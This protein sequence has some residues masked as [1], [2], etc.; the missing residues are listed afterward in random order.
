MRSQGLRPEDVLLD[1][2]CG[3]LRG[4]IHFIGY[5]LPGRYLGMDISAEVV[6]R[7][8]V[9]EL[10]IDAFREKAPEFV[11][12]DEF[13]F[14]AF[15][16]VPRYILAHSLFTHL[17]LRQVELCLANLRRFLG[18]RDADFFAT[19]TEVESASEHDGEA[20]YLGGRT[21]LTYTRDEFHRLGAATDWSTEYV[22]A[23]GHPKDH[24]P[25]EQRLFRF[26]VRHTPG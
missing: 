7:G 5:L 2:G 12:S 11:I 24:I 19:F 16:K 4:G 10:G 15:S 17:P 8:I 23:W 21:R 25:G 26:S 14:G 3:P 18:D 6:R 20:H 9:R 1:L 22:G 13:E